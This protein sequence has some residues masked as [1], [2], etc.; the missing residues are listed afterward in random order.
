MNQLV[1]LLAFLLAAWQVYRKQ[2][3]WLLVIL[4]FAAAVLTV[5]DRATHFPENRP[6]NTLGFSPSLDQDSPTDQLGHRYQ[7]LEELNAAQR[8]VGYAPVGFFGDNWPARISEVVT[9]KDQIEFVRGDGVAHSYQGFDGRYLKVI[10]LF[11]EDRQETLIV[12]R[13]DAEY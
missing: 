5:S 1:D 11:S 4:I 9:A 13:S 12:Y 6:E 8:A 10:R 2:L 3:F 7:S